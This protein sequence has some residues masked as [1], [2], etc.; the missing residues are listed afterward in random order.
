MQLGLAANSVEMAEFELLEPATSCAAIQIVCKW[1]VHASLASCVVGHWIEA[2]DHRSWSCRS[3][4]N[5][6]APCSAWVETMHRVT[7]PFAASLG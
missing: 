5:M 7:A 4:G 3:L 2:G 6:S 1:R